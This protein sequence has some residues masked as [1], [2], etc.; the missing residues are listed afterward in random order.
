MNRVSKS[1]EEDE[2]SSYHVS[3]VG[4]YAFPFHSTAVAVSAS[5]SRGCSSSEIVR[6]LITSSFCSDIRA[7]RGGR[8]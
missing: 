7:V 3:G 6:D 1:G 8:Y 2:G 4:D 5:T